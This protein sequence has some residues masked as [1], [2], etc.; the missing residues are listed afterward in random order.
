V[1]KSQDRV[2]TQAKN[3]LAAAG[4]DLPY[5]TRQILFHDQTEETDGDR[6]R[7]REG[8]PDRGDKV[9]SRWAAQQEKE[10]REK[11]QPASNSG[12]DVA[13]GEG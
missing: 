2:L 1:L 4:I 7:Q 5:P 9:R 11:Q 10:A 12:Q 6:S 13:T 3:E 8:W